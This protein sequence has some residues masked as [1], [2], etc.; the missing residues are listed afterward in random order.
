MADENVIDEA[1]ALRNQRIAEGLAQVIQ[2]HAPQIQNALESFGKWLSEAHE[3]LAPYISWIASVDWKQVQERIEGFPDASKQAMKVASS[4]GWF[5]NWQDGFK[6]VLELIERIRHAKSSG[7]IDNILMAYHNENWDYNA[8]LLA[9]KYPAR[10]NVIE[11]AI[12]AHRNLAPSGY[13]LSI[14]VFLAQ[15]DGIFSEVTRTPSALD[16]V[17]GKEVRRGSNWLSARIGDDEYAI[18]GLLPALELHE[19]DILKNKKARDEKTQQVGKTFDALNRHQVM[20]GEVS[21]YGT[22]INSVKAF[23]FLL[24]VALQVPGVL[25]YAEMRS[26]YKAKKNYI[27]EINLGTIAPHAWLFLFRRLALAN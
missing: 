20:H 22:E 11:A 8:G 16:R 9:E 4:E 6:D 3:K 25:E 2:E 5:F 12:N 17:K 14:P 1:I 15:A 27:F 26:E 21:D 7:E 13:S 24:F 19:L 23:S 10:K 18:G